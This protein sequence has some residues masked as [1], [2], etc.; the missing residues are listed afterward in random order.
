MLH[1][2]EETG[3]VREIDSP[4]NGNDVRFRKEGSGIGTKYTGLEITHKTSLLS[5]DDEEIDKWLKFVKDNPIP[6]VLIFHD[7]DTIARAAGLEAQN[8][9]SSQQE[10]DPEPDS[11]D[12]DLQYYDVM[13]MTASRVKALI[14]REG[15]NVDPREYDEEEDL[16]SL[17]KA[18]ADD[19]GLEPPPRTKDEPVPTKDPE[20]EDDDS[21]PEDGPDDSSETY[22][23]IMA[24]GRNQIR[25]VVER[26][27]LYVDPS[28]YK[29][30]DMPALRKAVATEMGLVSPHVEEDPAGRRRSF[31]L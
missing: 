13:G 10:D 31:D 18:V 14:E 12:A 11:M 25:E 15:L 9:S 27:R 8:A 7:Y 24:M 23:S 5:K 28:K 19:L 4:E 22:E 16:G 17:L 29:S 6:D 20:P 30:K 21:D 2:N 3:E 26:E 1:N